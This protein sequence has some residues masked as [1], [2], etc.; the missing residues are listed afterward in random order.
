MKSL[1]LILI[2]CTLGMG[3]AGT[4]SA[5]H[6]YQM[7]DRTKQVS[8]TGKVTRVEWT[9]PHVWFF[10]AVPDPKTK[11]V[12]EWGFEAGGGTAGFTRQGWKKGNFAPGTELTIIA[13]PLRNGE[14]GAGIVKVVLPDGSIFGEGGK[15]PGV[16]VT[17]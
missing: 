9:N 10:V 17:Q 3:C 4:A 7:F 12:V 1:R 14:P 13:N 2:A 15:G 6:S 8:Y 11:K 5:H 16:P